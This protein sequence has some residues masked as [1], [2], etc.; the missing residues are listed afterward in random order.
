MGRLTT[1]ITIMSY[2]VN[3]GNKVASSTMAAAAVLN[4]YLSSLGSQYV[5]ETH[6]MTSE[7]KL[8]LFETEVISAEGC[9]PDV[10][11]SYTTYPYQLF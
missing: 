3:Y 11:I 2:L 10:G 5:P 7:L 8:L 4:R 1:L 9:T 6:Q